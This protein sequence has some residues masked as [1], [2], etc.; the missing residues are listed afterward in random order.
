MVTRP[1][2]L[3]TQGVEGR[4]ISNGSGFVAIC[5][6]SDANLRAVNGG[7][8]RGKLLLKRN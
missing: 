4:K 3:V 8:R 2:T 5:V 1:E 7:L 6:T